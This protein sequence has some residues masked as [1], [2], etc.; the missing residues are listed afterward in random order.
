[1]WWAAFNKASYLQRYASVQP[2][3]AIRVICDYRTVSR[4][5]ALVI[6]GIIIPVEHV[7]IERER[8]YRTEES[9]IQRTTER[10]STL[11]RW[12]RAWQSA[13]GRGWT[14]KL[15]PN[16]R[17]WIGRNH[18]EVNYYMTQFLSGHGCFK[19]YLIRFKIVEDDACT[20][21]ENAAD[22]AEHAVLLCLKW[23]RERA[24]CRHEWV[25]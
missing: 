3:S 1:M 7:A 15:I 14:R 5:A 10:S 16:I 19:A 22:D 17:E 6:A 24:L 23:A 13:S 18:E 8:L 20:Y 12:Q 9:G 25:Q 2:V 21:W 11:A 4:G